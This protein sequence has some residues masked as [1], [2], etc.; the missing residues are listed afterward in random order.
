MIM[1]AFTFVVATKMV[2]AA[3]GPAMAQSHQGGYLGLNPG[4]HM[5]HSD[6]PPPPEFGSG[7][8]GN[9]G[10]NPGAHLAAPSEA[11][12]REVG[13]GQGGY[14]GMVPGVAPATNEPLVARSTA[15]QSLRARVGR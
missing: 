15:D 4:G 6:V 1:R 10:K 3:A 13:S 8:G 12:P 14:L 2:L 5:I 7:Q 11:P 9:L